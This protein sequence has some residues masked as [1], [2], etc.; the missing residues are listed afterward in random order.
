MSREKLPVKSVDEYWRFVTFVYPTYFKAQAWLYKEDEYG[1]YKGAAAARYPYKPPKD[2]DLEI[3]IGKIKVEQFDK[4]D[5]YK[6]L[7]T[8]IFIDP[9]RQKLYVSDDYYRQKLCK[10]AKSSYENPPYGPAAVE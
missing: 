8:L 5:Y 9:D 2:C 7:P 10:V 6:K 4:K 3:D 1:S